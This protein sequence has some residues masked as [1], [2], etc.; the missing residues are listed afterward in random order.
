MRMDAAF[1]DAHDLSDNRTGST[2]K[3]VSEGLRQGN[4]V[5]LRKRPRARQASRIFGG[6]VRNSRR[7]KAVA[8]S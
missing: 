2:K 8:H 4:T 6:R 7:F 3:Q 5:A 1:R